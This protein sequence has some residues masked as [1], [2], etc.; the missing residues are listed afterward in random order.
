VP[1]QVLAGLRACREEG[2]D[3]DSAWAAVVGS[4]STTGRGAVRLP[5]A[6]EHR[7]GWVE[8]LSATREEWRAC[9]HGEPTAISRMLDV[10]ADLDDHSSVAAPRPDEPGRLHVLPRPVS[11]G[12][13]VAA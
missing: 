5:H 3:F 11:I 13:R 1:A 7:R 4:A 12:H 9:W 8:A 10:F 2:L 6:T